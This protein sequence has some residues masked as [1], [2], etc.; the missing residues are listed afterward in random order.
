MSDARGKR[1]ASTTGTAEDTLPRCKGGQGSQ[2]C[3]GKMGANRV[4]GRGYWGARGGASTNSALVLEVLWCL[5]SRTRY[6]RLERKILPL[7]PFPLLYLPDCELISSPSTTL[8]LLNSAMQP[9]H[10]GTVL[11][12][13]IMC[14]VPVRQR[15]PA[16]TSVVFHTDP[17]RF[18]SVS[19]RPCFR[20][21]PS[22]LLSST[23][24]CSPFSSDFI[25]SPSSCSVFL[26]SYYIPVLFHIHLFPSLVI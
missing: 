18:H 5:L 17:F 8:P 25:A 9:W 1:D 22:L 2:E 19:F 20:T 12:M 10:W 16:C 26:S 14:S 7:L 3:S 13:P 15:R 21:F 24:H 4:R 23:L 6:L 11:P